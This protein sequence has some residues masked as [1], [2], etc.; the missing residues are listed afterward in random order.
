M[1]V[2]IA[3]LARIYAGVDPRLL[4][5]DGR[6]DGITIAQLD[7]LAGAFATRATLPIFF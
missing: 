6:L 3:D 2:D 7:Q 4:H 5:S 1:S